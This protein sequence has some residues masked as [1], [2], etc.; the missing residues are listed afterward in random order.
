MVAWRGASQRF[1]KLVG[2]RIPEFNSTISTPSRYDFAIGTHINTSNFV[3]VTFESIDTLF[4]SHVPHFDVRINGPRNNHIVLGLEFGARGEMTGHFSAKFVG[5]EVPKQDTS[6]IS[7][8]Q[9]LTG[10]RRPR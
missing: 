6:S 2:H 10:T 7:A 4:H 1:Q 8:Q 3:S 5:G 9:T